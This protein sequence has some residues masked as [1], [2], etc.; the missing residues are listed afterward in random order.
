MYHQEDLKRI[1]DQIKKRFIVLAVV[2]VL[3]L[4]GLVASL[5]VRWEWLTVLV[6]IALGS[7]LLI[8]IDLFLRPLLKYRAHLRVA[9]GDSTR[10]MEGTFI[11]HS[12]EESMIDG[13][14]CTSFLVEE[15]EAEGEPCQRLFYYDAELV[16]PSLQ[17]G[18][19]V[20]VRYYDRTVV[21][22]TQIA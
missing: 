20:R 2:S 5:V 22:M 21:D 8:G 15:Q 4:C 14:R 7:A 10:I 18:D 11:S 16:F 6:T 12:P 1:N 3:L 9:A 17:A 19:R 13:V